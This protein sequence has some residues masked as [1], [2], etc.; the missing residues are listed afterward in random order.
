MKHLPAILIVIGCA[1]ASPA[2]E[3]EAAWKAAQARYLAR[4]AEDCEPGE[5]G[6]CEAAAAA[7]LR[8]AA[9]AAKEC[10]P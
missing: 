8:D 4:V 10:Q 1:H 9:D 2:V 6:D 5:W 3:C 7:A